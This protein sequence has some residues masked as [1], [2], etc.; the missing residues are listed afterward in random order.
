MTL[1][2]P[3]LALLAGLAGGLAV[4]AM[5]LLRLRRRPVRVSSVMLWDA[6]ARDFEVNVPLRWLR[7]SWLLVLQLLVV[8][9]LAMALGRPMLEGGGGSRER[10]VLVVD[11]SASMGVGGSRTRFDE[12]IERG[13]AIA[14]R[15]LRDGASVA[16][17]RMGRDAEAV[18][19][20][21]TSMSEVSAALRGIER[22]D[23]VGDV[24][25][26]VR[27]ADALV[28]TGDEG[29]DGGN[30]GDGDARGG[31]RVVV[32]SDGGGGEQRLP[33]V[34]SALV[35]EAVGGGGGGLDA[36]L[37]N[38]GVSAVRA[39]RDYADPG[40]L[41][42][43]VRLDRAARGDEATPTPVVVSVDGA[44]VARRVVEVGD[45]GAATTIEVR[46]PGGG[47]LVVGIDRDDALVADN[48][49]G[50]SLD[51]ARRPRVLVV[52]PGGGDDRGWIV[53]DV[54]DAMRAGGSVAD[55]VAVDAA[56]ALELARRGTT[57]AFDLVVLDRVDLDARVF[58]PSGVLGFGRGDIA[59]DGGG[60]EVGGTYVLRWAREHPVL[61]DVSLGSVWVGV[62][63]DVGGDGDAGMERLARGR[64]GTLIGAWD[65]G[66]RDGAGGSAGRR[67]EVAFDP[68]ES[69]WP[70]DVGFAVFVASAVDWITGRGEAEAGRVWRAGDSVVFGDGLELGRVAVTGAVNGVGG[71]ER[72]AVVAD[73]VARLGVVER[74]G[75]YSV[76]GAAVVVVGV[77]DAGE[78][79]AA[80][81]D[82]IGVGATAVA[83]DSAGAG[84]RLG[85]RAL[86]PWFVAAAAAI[87]MLEWGLFAWRSRV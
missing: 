35:Y 57:E 69:T 83:A 39:Q 55:V 59:A 76:G 62:E 7:R 1:I 13:E 28:S 80:V 68:A 72:E 63:R 51:A 8:A 60:G 73:G 6:A 31:G 33:A 49:A 19:G 40:L 75:V 32:L 85:G 29:V 17:V 82:S 84:G 56:T 27:V 26:A 54:L 86:W 23:G 52:A 43:F 34:R 22:G 21:S 3:G 50:V 38:V 44:A 24:A 71:I 79:R 41:R 61:R 12:A 64:R 5:Y 58:G 48:V 36:P 46:W 9:L 87:A 74:A 77:L 25:A 70:L 45:D 65:G 37:D 14:R 66:T 53:G 11:A 10:V 4:V 81:R 67:V 30:G 15:A 16:V 78:T 18:S 2:A 47:V 42:V 20:L